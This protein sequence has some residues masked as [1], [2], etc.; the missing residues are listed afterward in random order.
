M[1]YWNTTLY[2]L[3]AM[4]ILDVSGCSCELAELE[5]ETDLEIDQQEMVIDLLGVLA[6]EK[7]AQLNLDY[8]C[9]QLISRWCV[10][11]RRDEHEAVYN[12][13]RYLGL[14][15]LAMI[16]AHRLYLDGK[17]PYRYHEVRPNGLYLL[18]EDLYRRERQ[19]ELDESS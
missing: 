2:H 9:M 16:K 4:V 17:L 10:L 3:P 5:L 8:H 12:Y 14:R 15:I 1:S 7:D 19:R 11:V 6:Q 13:M 18:R